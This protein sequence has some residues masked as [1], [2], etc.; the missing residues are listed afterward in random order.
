MR[1]CSSLLNLT[2]ER[3]KD[4]KGFEIMG[5]LTSCSLRPSW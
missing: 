2:T 1:D 3:T 4:T 5:Y